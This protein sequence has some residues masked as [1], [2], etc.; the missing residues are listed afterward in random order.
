MKPSSPL[1]ALTALLLLAATTADARVAVR[2]RR[3]PLDTLAAGAMS[4]FSWDLYA[5]VNKDEGANLVYSP[6]SIMFAVGMTFGGADGDTASEMSSALHFDSIGGQGDV[7]AGLGAL[8]SGLN[9]EG[10]K[11]GVEL[12]VVNRIWAA[13]GFP[14]SKQ[15]M[16]VVTKA[17][18]AGIEQADFANAAEQARKTINAWVEKHTNERIKDL[19]PEGILDGSTVMVLVNAIYFKGQWVHKF[20]K[21]DTKP[22]TFVTASGDKVQAPL[23]HQTA[24]LLH[25]AAQGLQIVDLPYKNTTL[26]MDLIV[27][28]DARGLPAVEK[29]LTSDNVT[30]WLSSLSPAEDLDLTMPR[31]QV[32]V[33]LSL[34]PPLMAMGMKQ[35]F[36]AGAANFTGML[37]AKAKQSHQLY[38]SAV[39]HKAFVLVDE[40]GSEAAAATAVVM[41]DAA[42]RIPPKVRADHPF[43][44]IIRDTKTGAILFVGRVTDPTKQ[45]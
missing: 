10:R 25:T 16:G 23:M 3:P 34:A 18:G 7:A 33:P 22:D 15:F 9:A 42:A 27:P 37:D 31:F 5:Q 4:S 30:T 6:A 11:K 17:W 20:D 8:M 21:K 40:E 12:R 45:S 43:V 32:T 2:P 39:V 13:K 41:T 14:W 36:D 29:Q 1:A 26:A 24:T 19:L 38:I 28:D 35:A 44:W